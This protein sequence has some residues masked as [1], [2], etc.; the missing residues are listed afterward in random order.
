MTQGLLYKTFLVFVLFITCLE[1]EAQT[2]RVRFKYLMNE[3]RLRKLNSGS[4]RL[5]IKGANGKVYS[6]CP[7]TRFKFSVTNTQGTLLIDPWAITSNPSRCDSAQFINDTTANNLRIQLPLRSRI[8][9]PTVSVTLHYRTW[10]F[11]VNTVGLKVR[12]KVKDYN[13]KEYRSSAVAGNFN[14]GFSAGYSF[15]WTKFTHRSSNSFSITPGASLGFSSAVLSKEILKK[16]VDV[17]SSTGNLVLSPAVSCIIARNDI[18][19]ILSYG[20][21][22]MTGKNASAWAYQ[23][24]GFFGL[25]IS[26]SFKL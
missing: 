22:K 8:G 10:V 15:G 20:I 23:G 11:G 13:G 19:I 24:K 17:S 25:G 16:N 26:A 2:H 5:D 3:R 6:V 7:G 1:A 18:G 12:P 9:D 21:E 4:P 14:L